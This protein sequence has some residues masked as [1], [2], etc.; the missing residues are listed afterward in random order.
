MLYVSNN[1]KKATDSEA[2]AARQV[3]YPPVLAA[4]RELAPVD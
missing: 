3:D 1:L 4:A 2:S